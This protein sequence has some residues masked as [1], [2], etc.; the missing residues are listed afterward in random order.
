MAR[1]FDGLVIVDQH[2]AHEAVLAE[3]LLGGGEAQSL[4][5]PIRLELTSRET[6][7]LMAHLGL[8]ADLGWEIE[9]FRG[10]SFLMRALPG[11][12]EGQDAASL[13]ADLLEELTA[14]QNLDP[15]ALR[16][17]LAER[18]ACRAAV[19]AGD[20]LT[21]EEQQAL[22]D[23]LLEAWSPT[24]CPHGRPVLFTLGVEEMERRFL[25]R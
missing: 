16:E 19:K 13:M 9:P 11:P 15:D 24:T 4:S 5:A 2:A 12:L 25:R 23:E 10:N 22:L 7:L 1:T 8:F 20:L 17:K 6:E 21:I 14:G 3:R 18:S